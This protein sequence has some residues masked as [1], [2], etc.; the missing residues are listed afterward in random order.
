MMLV[1]YFQ[2]TNQLAKSIW[3]SLTRELFLLVPLAWV[4]QFFGL[5]YFWYTFPVTEVVTTL[6]AIG[7]YYQRNRRLYLL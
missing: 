3:V 2:A 7:L 4:F 5:R 1:V 6:L